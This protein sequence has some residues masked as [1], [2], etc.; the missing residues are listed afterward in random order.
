MM[1]QNKANEAVGRVHQKTAA[2]YSAVVS[3]F[4]KKGSAL[5]HDGAKQGE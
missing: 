2:P 1:V 5:K 4:H 3:E